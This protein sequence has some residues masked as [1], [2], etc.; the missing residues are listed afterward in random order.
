LYTSIAHAHCPLC[1]AATGAAVA[2]TRFYGV[3]D[4][5]V[6]VF[7]GGFVLSTSFWFDK[8]LRKR[9]RGNTYI[10]LQNII[11]TIL[12]LV[13]TILSFIWANLT[14]PLASSLFGINKLI[15]GTVIGTVVSF[16]AFEFHKFARK[17]FE[18]NFIPFQGIVL[19]LLSLVLIN[20]GFYTA[21][22]L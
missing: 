9:N 3:D 1:T 22:W 12:G 8:I 16:S 11:I 4:L 17:R 19:T 10:P 14:G 20:L 13:F 2:V 7:I 5:A 18:R 21:G 6:G 15:L